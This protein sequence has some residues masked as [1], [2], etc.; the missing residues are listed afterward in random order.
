MRNAL[1]PITLRPLIPHRSHSTGLFFVL[2]HCPQC[3]AAQ[4]SSSVLPNRLSIHC[5]SIHLYG[6]A[7]PLHVHFNKNYW[8]YCSSTGWVVLASPYKMKVDTGSACLADSSVLWSICPHLPPLSSP[9]LLPKTH[10]T[11]LPLL[12]PLPAA[13]SS[14]P[15][16]SNHPPLLHFP[17]HWEILLLPWLLLSFHSLPK[18]S[19]IKVDAAF[20]KL[21]PFSQTPDDYSYSVQAGVVHF[22]VPSP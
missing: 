1:C 19:T 8:C 6:W 4:L 15:S 17:P 3:T 14:C 9:V 16:F 11:L 20:L 5:L 10:Y 18:L 21:L 13:G 7:G 2:C 12:S 22:S